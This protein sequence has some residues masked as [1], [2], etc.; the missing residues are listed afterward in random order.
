MEANYV[1]FVREAF[2]LIREGHLKVRVMF[3][4][5]INQTQDLDYD[6]ENHFFILYYHFLKH[7]FGLRYCNDSYPEQAFVHVALDEVPVTKEKFDNFKN[8]LSS[9]S[10]HPILFNAGV[11]IPK[12]S[13]YAVNSKEHVILQAVDVILGAIQF[14]LND[15]Y[16][17]K[18]PGQ[19]TRA[20]RTRSKER[21][22]KEVSKL[23]RETYP[24][25]NIGASTGE[26]QH[27]DRWNH[28]YAH[29]LFVPVGSVKDLSRGKKKQGKK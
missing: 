2:A 24:N 7:A 19:R 13:I 18:P 20:K 5:N 8:Y 9:L 27:T 17:E 1:A 11:C 28:R 10:N 3:T 23:I 4:Q 12:A 26:I 15:K 16:K 29:W 25:F 14:R 6:E 22:F 21:V